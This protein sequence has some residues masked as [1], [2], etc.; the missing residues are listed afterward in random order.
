MKNY[1]HFNELEDFLNDIDKE[2]LSLVVLFGSL[3]KGTFT[4]H[5]DIDMLCVY[6]KEFKDMRERF[7][8][9]YRFSKGLVQPETIT[10]QE[11]KDNLSEGNSFLYHILDEGYILYN[12]ILESTL[13]SWIEEGKKNLNTIYFPPS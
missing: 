5:S 3:T 4:Q 12:K 1:P 10:L 13:K 11:F 7:L 6:D 9:S 8:Q 2:N